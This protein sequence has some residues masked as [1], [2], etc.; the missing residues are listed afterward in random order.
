MDNVNPRNESSR[1]VRKVL[2]LSFIEEGS[3]LEQS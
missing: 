3:D 1:Q 2:K